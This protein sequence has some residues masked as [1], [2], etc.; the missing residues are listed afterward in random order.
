MRKRMGFISNSSSSSFII[1]GEQISFEEAKN[2]EDCIWFTEKELSEGEDYIELTPEI[3]KTLE[4]QSRKGN[5]NISFSDGVILKN[6]RWYE[7]YDEEYEPTPEDLHKCI[8]NKD[9]DQHSTG[10]DLKYNS[11][12]YF[13]EDS[14]HGD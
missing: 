10:N 13:I 7:R 9:I 4:E 11:Y 12:R 14:E 6:S 2:F 3:I 5:L 8:L 1:T